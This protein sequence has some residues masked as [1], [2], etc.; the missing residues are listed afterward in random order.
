MLLAPL[1]LSRTV[2][3]QDTFTLGFEGAAEQT[4][5]GSDTYYTTL[6]HVG[7]VNAQGWSYGAVAENATIAEVTL[8]GTASEIAYTGGFDA[9]EVVDPAKNPGVTSGM[10]SAVVLHLKKGTTLPVGTTSRISNMKMNFVVPAEG[11]LAR[12]L[13][14][15]NL[16]GSGE[17]VPI[18][19]TQAGDTKTAI[20]QSKE[21]TFPAP[22][23]SCCDDPVIVGFSGTAIRTGAPFTGLVNGDPAHDCSGSGGDIVVNR[24]DGGSDT[25][26]VYVGM[27]SN[28]PAAEPGLQGWSYGVALDGEGDWVPGSV[29]LTG[30]FAETAYAGG[31]DATEVIDPAKQTPA[32][33]RGMVSAVVL[34]LK[35]GTTL[36]RP[37]TDSVAATAIMSAAPQG[38]ADQVVNLKFKDGLVGSGEPVPLVITIGG[39]SASACN[40]TSASVRV[41]FRLGGPPPGAEFR[42]GFVNPDMKFDIADPIWIINDLFRD[43]PPTPCQDAADA[44]DDGVYDSSDAVYLINYLF[45][46][47]P[48]PVGPSGEC[49]LDPT[50]DTLECAGGP[51]C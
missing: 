26:G 6:A 30:T 9:T 22:V 36:P 29:T 33:Q 12:L 14:K 2:S 15:E 18:V 34:H 49:A 17:P 32:G 11:G 45:K 23:P 43:G 25:Q 50:E 4:A 38:Q 31:F 3:G 39:D 21:I 20:L 10:V 8:T 27:V 35:K 19:I 40:F 46:A 16:V 48:A 28:I 47:G 5:S 13:Y 41:V 51:T 7:A 44:N 1:A 37:G 24:G 42:R